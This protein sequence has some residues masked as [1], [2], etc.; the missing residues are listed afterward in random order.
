MKE[1]EKELIS[2]V[3][4]YADDYGWEGL[5]EELFPGATAGEIVLD[6]YNSGLIPE[7]IMERFLN[8]E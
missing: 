1:Y 8:D 4:D 2:V 5:F 3:N 6:M 7:D